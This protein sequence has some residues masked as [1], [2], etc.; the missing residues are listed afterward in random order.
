M[1][2]VPSVE[3]RE[4]I[5]LGIYF[6]YLISI[7]FFRGASS[8]NATWEQQ[9]LLDNTVSFSTTVVDMLHIQ[10]C[11]SDIKMA[12]LHQYKMMGDDRINYTRVFTIAAVIGRMEECDRGTGL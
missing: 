4:K 7:F 9:Q 6:K 2:Y 8:C 5:T 10:Q 12:I 3:D 1:W 11:H